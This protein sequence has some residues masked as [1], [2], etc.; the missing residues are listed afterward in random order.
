LTI[1]DYPK[2]LKERTFQF[3]VQVIQFLKRIQ[4]SKENDVIKYQLVKSVT[5][6]GANYEEAVGAYSRDDFKYRMSICFRESK[7]TNYW[8]RIV[9]E[10]GFDRCNKL[11]ELIGESLEIKNIFG[12]IMKKIN[13]RRDVPFK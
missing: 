8:L 7:E 12:S 13:Y 2:D 4:Y 5:S 10:I 11:N 3:A 6:I 9:K 1:H